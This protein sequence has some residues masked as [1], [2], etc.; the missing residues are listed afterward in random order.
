MHYRPG[1]KTNAQFDKKLLL[2]FVKHHKNV[3]KE[4]ESELRV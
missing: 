2:D 3:K 4:D 1:T